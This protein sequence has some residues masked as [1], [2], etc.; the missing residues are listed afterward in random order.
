MQLFCAPPRRGQILEMRIQIFQQ[1]TSINAVL[2][3]VPEILIQVG[4]ADEHASSIA[5]GSKDAATYANIVFVY[6]LIAG[7]AFI[8][9]Q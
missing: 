7:F 9:G 2:Y 3:Y 8:W 4:L 6:I 5:T 1:L